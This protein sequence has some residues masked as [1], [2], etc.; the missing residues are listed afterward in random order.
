MIIM[1]LGFNLKKDLM[2]CVI[3]IEKR[4]MLSRPWASNTGKAKSIV[5]YRHQISQ[6]ITTRPSSS[7]TKTQ[8]VGS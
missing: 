8:A 2:N 6:S 1:W 3:Q 4:V 5:G 7:A